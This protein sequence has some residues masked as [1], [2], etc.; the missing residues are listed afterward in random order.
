MRL[1]SSAQTW[2]QPPRMAGSRARTADQIT[3]PLP[4]PVAPAIRTWEPSSRSSH[5]AP[6]S[7]QPTGSA[8]GLTTWS[9]GSA[10]I[11]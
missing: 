2:A 6:S 5:G 3:E 9:T 4:E 10:A 8:S 11:G 1:G 7:R